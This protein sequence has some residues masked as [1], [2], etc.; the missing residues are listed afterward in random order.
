MLG[1][2]YCFLHAVVF[3][4]KFSSKYHEVIPDGPYYYIK[5]N[6][7]LRPWNATK[8]ILVVCYVIYVNHS[9]NGI[10]LLPWNEIACDK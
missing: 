5:K 2:S 9:F 3:V 10:F 7:H 1:N 8:Q 6:E 4:C